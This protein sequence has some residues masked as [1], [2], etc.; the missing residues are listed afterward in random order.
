V[1]LSVVIPSYHRPRR[2]AA[3]L[4]HLLRDLPDGCEILPVIGRDDECDARDDPRVTVIRRTH[5]TLPQARNRGIASSRGRIVLFLDD[6][7]VP[8]DTVAAAHIRLHEQHPEF[9]AI[10]GGV[11]DTNNAGDKDTVVVLEEPT[12]RY[13]CDYGLS[14]KMEVDA[15]HGAHMS[16]KREVFDTVLFDPWFFGNAHFEEVDLAMRLRRRGGRILFCPEVGVKHEIE[17]R[18]GCR[19]ARGRLLRRASRFRN[20]AFCFAKNVALQH[21]PVFLTAQRHELE[22]VSRKGASHDM[23]LVACACP[24]TLTGLA[25]GRLRR[26]IGDRRFR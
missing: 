5:E 17:P 18:G 24:A 7:T 2:L 1:Q 21:L 10:A 16:F 8:D 3:L 4:R 25:R 26:I 13:E 22:Y 6:D 23:Q 20:R 19:A 15:C 14:A 11:H 9:D 12:M